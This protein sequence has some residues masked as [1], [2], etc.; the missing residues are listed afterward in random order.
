MVVRVP[1]ERPLLLVP[2]PLVPP[3]LPSEAELLG[4]DGR[5]EDEDWKLL[6]E[7][8]LWQEEGLEAELEELMYAIT[9]PALL[10]MLEVIVAALC[11][12]GLVVQVGAPVSSFSPS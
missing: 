2:F 12:G 3:L 7:L 10:P 5:G 6:L 4:E 8:S 9:P 1:L 11:V